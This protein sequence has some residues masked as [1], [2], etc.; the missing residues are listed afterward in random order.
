MAVEKT[1]RRF[2]ICVTFF[3]SS[4]FDLNSYSPSFLRIPFETFILGLGLTW[5][6]KITSASSE[7]V[8]KV[9]RL[10]GQEGLLVFVEGKWLFYKIRPFVTTN[11]PCS[12]VKRTDAIS[13]AV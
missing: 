6:P 3:F 4:T 1:H 13:V 7:V 11:V 5:S 9:T 2:D 10:G 8:A 12:W